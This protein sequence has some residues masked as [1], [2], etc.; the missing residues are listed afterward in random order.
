MSKLTVL[1]RSMDEGEAIK[2][3]QLLEFL[4]Q[5]KLQAEAKLRKE[6]KSNDDNT[7]RKTKSRKRSVHRD[8]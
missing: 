5:Q 1:H 3:G 6:R 8:R 4:A 7:M 2:R